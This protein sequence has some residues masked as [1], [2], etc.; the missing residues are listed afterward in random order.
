MSV[1]AAKSGYITNNPAVYSFRD[2]PVKDISTNTWTISQVGNL[3]PSPI[4]PNPGFRSIYFPQGSGFQLSTSAQFGFGSGEFTIEGWFLLLKDYSANKVFCDFRSGQT[5]VFGFGNTRKP[6]F[7]NGSDRFSTTALTVNTW[8]H[9]VWQR[10]AGQF[11]MYLDGTSI[12][13]PLTASTGAASSNITVG[14]DNNISSAQDLRVSQFR[15]V[16]GSAVYSGNFTPS[17][18]PLTAITGTSL[19]LATDAIGGIKTQG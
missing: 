8:H 16:K 1:A 18:V 17:T 4:E 5:L 12:F 13:T 14:G 3:Q 19:L 6:Y 9:V 10:R 11:Q 7:F 15:I 2:S